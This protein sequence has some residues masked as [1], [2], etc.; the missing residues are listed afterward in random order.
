MTKVWLWPRRIDPYRPQTQ[1]TLQSKQGFAH[2]PAMNA[3]HTSPPWPLCTHPYHG[4][5]EHVYTMATL[6]TSLPWPLCTRPHH[7]PLCTCVL[8]PEVL[9]LYLAWYSS[10]RVCTAAT[11]MWLL[12]RLWVTLSISFLCC[13]EWLFS[14]FSRSWTPQR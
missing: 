7:G 9:P 2:V 13:D 3:L 8:T 10:R 6:H 4:H 14:R 1:A 5:F 11:M 12:T